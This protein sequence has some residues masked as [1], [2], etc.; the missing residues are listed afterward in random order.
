MKFPRLVFCL[1]FFASVAALDAAEPDK[2]ENEQFGKVSEEY[3]KGWLAAHPLNATALGFHEYDGRI[4]DFSR[5]ALD[6]EISRLRRFD[7]R[8]KKFDPEKLRP[9]SAIDLRILQAA[10]NRDLFDMLE[11]KSF[12]NNP[13]TYAQALDVSIYIKRNFASLE[14]RARSIILIENQTPNLVIAAKTNLAATLPKPYVELAIE[15]A[16]GSAD[17]LKKDLVEA[18]KSLK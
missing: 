5:L 10:V 6:A 13:M 2:A 15:I 1:L 11:T 17:F 3:V 18:L 4:K 16:R 9:V 8:L 7:E 14:D 12:E